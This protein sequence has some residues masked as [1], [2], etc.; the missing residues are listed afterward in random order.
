MIAYEPLFIHQFSYPRDPLNE[1]LV[2]IW[3]KV[4]AHGSVAEEVVHLFRAHAPPK[5]TCTANGVFQIHK[6]NKDTKR[7]LHAR[8]SRIT[9]EAVRTKALA[10]NLVTEAEY[11]VLVEASVR[12]E[13]DENAILFKFPDVWAMALLPNSSA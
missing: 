7:N 8:L 3:R 4:F 2:E 1:Q 11:T 12:L 6:Y 5:A 13:H 9:I 10:M